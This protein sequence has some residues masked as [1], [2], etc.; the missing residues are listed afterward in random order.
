[1]AYAKEAPLDDSKTDVYEIDQGP[2]TR[3][4]AHGS[5]T[6]LSQTLAEHDVEDNTLSSR[7]SVSS[8]AIRR[9]INE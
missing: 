8:T 3:L 6:V 7:A 4:D 1:M 5:V 9:P 2:A